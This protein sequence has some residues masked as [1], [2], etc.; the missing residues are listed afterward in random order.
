LEEVEK[1][2][3]QVSDINI[4]ILV[5]NAGLGSAGR[6]DKQSQ[7]NQVNMIQV[8]VLAPTVLTHLFLP[9]MIKRNKGGIIFI[10]SASAYQPLPYHAV[11]G[12][13]KSYLSSFGL[14]IWDEVRGTKIKVVICEPGTVET[15]FQQVSGQKQHHGASVKDIARDAI[16]TLLNDK[17]ITV[18]GW[19]VWARAN[20]AS[21]FP[22]KWVIPFARKV[23]QKHVP[24][25]LL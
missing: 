8:N 6:F 5:N 12:A 13:S 16:N 7:Q 19:F 2:F 20:I 23:I 10:S 14:A 1:L 3:K 4:D 15:E 25:E 11:Y 18:Y 17:V 21:T 22:R 24:K 9:S